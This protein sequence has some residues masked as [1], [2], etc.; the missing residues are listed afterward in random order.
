M[1]AATVAVW[2]IVAPAKSNQKLLGYR[3][4]CG[5]G[6]YL[7]PNHHPGHI[8]PAHAAAA[9]FEA[10]PRAKHQSFLALVFAMVSPMPVELLRYKS[11]SGAPPA[12]SRAENGCGL[13]SSTHL[14]NRPNVWRGNAE[15]FADSCSQCWWWL[16]SSWTSSWGAPQKFLM[17]HLWSQWRGPAAY[18][19]EWTAQSGSASTALQAERS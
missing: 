11:V 2:A 13:A 4:A 14:R 8:R 7:A 19:A 10:S 6:A 16:D 9:Y 1:I 17:R 12:E 3:T 15:T 5:R 18:R